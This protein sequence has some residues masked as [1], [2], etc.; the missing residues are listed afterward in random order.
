MSYILLNPVSG[1][2]M[3]ELWK[4][5]PL[6]TDMLH[7]KG[8]IVIEKWECEFRKDVEA[9]EELKPFFK[10]YEPYFPIKPSDG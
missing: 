7:S 4:K 9:D 5:T 3:Q 1:L 10:E 2:T 6:K 8:H